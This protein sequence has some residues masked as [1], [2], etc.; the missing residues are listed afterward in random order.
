MSFYVDLF[1]LLFF[2]IRQMLVTVRI[3]ITLLVLEERLKILRRKG[4]TECDN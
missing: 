1:F 3:I 2:F 4:W